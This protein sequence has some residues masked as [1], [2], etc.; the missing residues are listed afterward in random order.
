MSEPKI[1]V[2]EDR[3]VFQRILEEGLTDGG[4]K[5]CWTD[6]TKEARR[7][8]EE[9]DV[10]LM[11]L[12]VSEIREIPDGPLLEEQGIALLRELRKDPRY[13]KELLPVIGTT[14]RLPEDSPSWEETFMA[15]GGNAFFEYP[16]DVDLLVAKVRELL[17]SPKGSS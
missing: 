2:V 12:D 9:N 1:L 4:Y 3:P 13:T 14:I 10:I 17:D 8:I 6:A 16:L 7:I 15:A 5:T 11:T